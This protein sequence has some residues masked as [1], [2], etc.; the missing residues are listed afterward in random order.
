VLSALAPLGYPTGSD[1]SPDTSGNTV[2]GVLRYIAGTDV[3]RATSTSI[4]PNIFGGLLMV[5]VMLLLGRLLARPSKRGWRVGVPM[6]AIMAW[7]LLLSYS[8]GAWVG[9]AA[10]LALFALLR[11]RKALPG[12][13]VAGGIAL[14]L[15]A[16]SGFGKHL[17]AGFLVE[18]QATAMRVGEYKD[19]LSFISQYPLFGVGYGFYS[20][21]RIGIHLPGEIYVGVS[22]IY[23]LMAL[24][25]G[26]IGIAGFAAV[27]GTLAIW[28]AKRYRVADRE[29]Q[30]WIASLAAALFAA[31]VAGIADHY[32]VTY[33]HMAALFW[34]LVGALTVAARLATPPAAAT[35]PPG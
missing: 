3:W 16:Q 23:L 34:C 7:A 11:F 17:V 12:I 26:L 5:G 31:A 30:V 4:D 8:R 28:T 2:C 9:L 19:A 22:N 35:G 27:L 6:L 1:C 15:L 25:I 29:G 21:W 13:A 32:F 33:P 14:L 10:G 24:E 20:Q 18:D